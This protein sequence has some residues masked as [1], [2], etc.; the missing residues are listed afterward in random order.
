MTICLNEQLIGFVL[1]QWVGHAVGEGV[2]RGV[3]GLVGVGFGVSWTSPM[4]GVL[5]MTA[6]LELT[7][8]L[9]S[10]SLSNAP[11]IIVKKNCFH[12]AREREREKKEREKGLLIQKK[13]LGLS[14]WKA[15]DANMC[16]C[17]CAHFG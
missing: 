4:V 17:V 9:V 14:C 5:S 3:G 7:S 11:A 12:G 13:N 16:V 8:S 6:F 10:L 1:S 15:T 2:G